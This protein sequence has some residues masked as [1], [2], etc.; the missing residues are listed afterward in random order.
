M[1]PRNVLLSAGDGFVDRALCVIGTVAFSQFPEF[2]QQ[3]VQR[4]GGHLDEARR[5]LGLFTDSAAQSGISLSRLIEQTTANSD[6]TVARLGLVMKDTVTRVDD[7]AAAQNA[8]LHAS[9]FT[10]P[11]VFLQHLDSGIAHATWKVFQ[12]AVPTTLEGLLYALTGMITLLALY[13]FGFK[14]TAKRLWERRHEPA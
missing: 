7:L 10:R 8:I 12:P 5:Q 13:H 1:K 9:P 6:P 2:M 3:Y 4:L 11:F 14:F